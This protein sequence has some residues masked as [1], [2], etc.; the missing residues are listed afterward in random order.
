[1]SQRALTWLIFM[2]ALL[3]GCSRLYFL[4]GAGAESNDLALQ[5]STYENVR[6][7]ILD[8][9]VRE[10][11]KDD[12]D[13]IFYGAL[14]GMTSS[15]DAHSQFLPPDL[16]EYLS[17]TTKGSFAGIGIEINSEARGLTVLTPLMDTPAWRAGIFPG[18]RVVRIDGES[19]EGMSVDDCKARIMGM[20]DTPLRLTLERDGVEKPFDVTVRRAVIRIKSVQAE[21]ILADTA[22][23]APKIGYV[24]VAQFQM[25][26]AEDLDAS[27]KRLEA[28]GMTALI[29]DLRQNPGGLLDEAG[30]MCDLFLRDGPIV[31]VIDRD[32]AQKLR[33]VSTRNVEPGKTHPDY[34]VAVLVDAQSASAAEIVA[35]ALQDRGRAV[36]VGDKTYG[37]FSVQ[38]VIPLPLGRESNALLLG[39][40]DSTRKIGALKLT[41]AR[42]KTPKGECLDGQG[43]A[44]DFLVTSN[45]E[46][47]KEL[48][49]SRHRRHLKDNDPRVKNGGT[50]PVA[51]NEK[52]EPA[53]FTDRQLKKAISVLKEKLSSR[54]AP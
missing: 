40:R 22:A 34:P 47:Q 21:E 41:I 11:N 15:L 7:L 30:Q 37:K 4:G 6:G 29:L 14:K 27:L 2:T 54:I 25:N 38:D 35:G 18:D 52:P 51:P 26:T 46:Q 53:A 17:T 45:L 13:K 24:Q 20:P 50:P 28:L 36:L 1:M 5:Q 31:S 9:Y 19:T 12:Q 49:L 39:K 10:L 43:I 44:P 48:I 32:A 42:Y 3:T 8:R 16:F 33:V 23:G